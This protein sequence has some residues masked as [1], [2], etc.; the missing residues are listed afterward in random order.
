MT[1]EAKR[2]IYQAITD[3]II[4]DLERGVRPWHRPWTSGNAT[5]SRP[6]RANGILYQGINVVLLWIEASLKGYASPTWMTF[7]QAQA[8]G[9]CVRKGEKGS[10]VVYA[11]AITR[12]ETDASTGEDSELRIPFLKSYTVFNVAQIDGLRP[13]PP[14]PETADRLTD[15]DRIMAADAFFAT[16]GADLR[17]GGARAFYAPAVDAIT[18]PP[19]AAFESPGSYYATLAHEHIHWTGHSRR[20]NRLEKAPKAS[21]PYAREELVAELGSAFLCADLG[22]SDEPREDHAS[23]LAS[24]LKVLREDKRAIVTAASAAQR[25]VNFLHESLGTLPEAEADEAAAA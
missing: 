13:M 19:F 25:A 12:T 7:K 15:V 3:K 9:A 20:L 22:I 1:Y 6:L 11:N 17:H 23:Y 14:A 10:M 5:S 4:A 16:V 18:L 2:D 21:E 24:W 8:V